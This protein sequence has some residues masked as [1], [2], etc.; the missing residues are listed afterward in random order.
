MRQVQTIVLDS[1][2]VLYQAGDDVAELL[3][4]YVAAHGGADAARVE[5]EY[6]RA[7]RGEASAAEFW[8]RVGLDGTHE[9]AYLAGHRVASDL[10]AFL[11]WAGGGGY[12]LACLS[13][14]VSEWSVKLRLHFGLERHIAQWVVSGDVKA[15]K[16]E[17]AIYAA[18][19]DRLGVAPDS[20]LLVDDRVRNLDGARRAGLRTVLLGT[21]RS[22]PG[23][24]QVAS[25]TELSER[26]AESRLG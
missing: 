10:Y 9:D 13:N 3:V 23:H 24:P 17:P 11:E 15:R 8:R 5:A 6:L 14:D 18:L 1:M 21:P 7:S 12:H 19:V 16:P 20:L 2:G 26:L 22:D 4:P 25:L